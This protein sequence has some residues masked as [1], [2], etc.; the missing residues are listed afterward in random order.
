M[1][2]TLDEETIRKARHLAVEQGVSLSQLLA[3]HLQALVGQGE[4][5]EQARR[6][7]IRR[8]KRGFPL[9]T[10]GKIGWRREDLYER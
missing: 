4:A 6:R 3:H 7:A 9:G 10:R 2:I 1:T 8:M 5:Y